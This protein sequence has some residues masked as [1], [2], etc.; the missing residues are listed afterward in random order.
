MTMEQDRPWFEEKCLE[1]F[2]R[3]A[4]IHTTSDPHSAQTPS[5]QGQW[6]L[7]RVLLD[8]LR[9][10]G[11]SDCELTE[12]C[13]VI[14]RIPATPGYESACPIGF[15]SHMDTSPDVNGK[16]VSPQ[17]W[18][19]YDGSPI[20]LASGAIHDPDRDPALSQYKGETIITTDGTSLLGADDKAGIAEIMTAVE[21]FL[22]HPEHPHGDLEIIFTP[23]EE[24]GRGVDKLDISSLRSRYAYTLDGEDEGTYNAECFSAYG[25]QVSFSGRMIHP[26]SARGVLQNA[27]SMAGAFVAAMPRNESPEATDGRF[28]FYCP[29][30]ISGTMEQAEVKLIV[31]DFDLEEVLRR[32]RH[33]E[34]IARTIEGSYP[35]GTVR[36]D[37][38][39][40]Y[41]NLGQFVFKDPR[42]VDA[43][44]KGIEE[45]GME[46]KELIIRGGTDGARL[47]EQGL[48]CPNIFAGGQNLHSPM[49]W[50]A[51]PA[52]VRAAKTIVNI[53]E[54][55]TRPEFADR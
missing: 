13:Y 49:E 14:A 53:A 50:V 52:M 51:L 55:W 35:G 43:L 27:V 5:S 23:D 40:Q 30:E 26:G 24:I 28:G 39:K 41:L 37:A 10:L 18:R 8:E 16:N 22:T 7:A 17:V 6:D 3:Y 36:V 34:Q 45:T 21:Y 9:S 32:V 4:K 1:R 25:V 33:L 29:T 48:P 19:N 44:Q 46:P 15:C 42:I 11:V 31:R 12:F 20:Q 54:I 47:S 38:K 2:V